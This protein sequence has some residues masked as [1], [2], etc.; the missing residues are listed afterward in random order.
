M[1][2]ATTGEDTHPAPASHPFGQ[3]EYPTS[4][5]HADMSHKQRAIDRAR[6]LTARPGRYQPD[7]ALIA[8]LETYD[9]A[10]LT[11]RIALRG[12]VALSH[13][14]DRGPKDLPARACG[15]PAASA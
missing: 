4:P 2:A 14:R 12:S 15:G 9:H 3:L 1:T 10:D 11:E 6:P 13:Q 5:E 7:D 8:F